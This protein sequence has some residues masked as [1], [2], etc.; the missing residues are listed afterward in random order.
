M[1]Y[2]KVVLLSIGAVCLLN[3]CAEVNQS[4]L[5]LQ[6]SQARLLDL[7]SSGHVKPIVADLHVDTNHPNSENG[8]ITDE[9][10]LSEKEVAELGSMAEIRSYGLYKSAVR[11]HADVIV[12]ATFNFRYDE[13]KKGYLL[14]IVGYP[15]SFENFKTADTNDLKLIKM[16]KSMDAKE[17]DKTKAIVM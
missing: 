13:S 6:E 12:A 14:T 1:K 5:R 4:T 3:S 11:H 16:N 15:A 7:I 10:F 9:W 2:L 8:R 17:E